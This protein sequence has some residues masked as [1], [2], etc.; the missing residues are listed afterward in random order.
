VFDQFISGILKQNQEMLTEVIDKRL[1]IA[2]YLRALRLYGSCSELYDAL[3][4]LFWGPGFTRGWAARQPLEICEL[5]FERARAGR[6]DIPCE[7]AIK[8]VQEARPVQVGPDLA[9]VAQTV[10]PQGLPLY[11]V[12]TS[13]DPSSESYVAFVR[14]VHLPRD[15]LMLTARQI[16]GVPKITGAIW[17]PD[18]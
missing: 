11:L 15:V 6:T 7:E 1:A 10:L 18:Q 12:T 4:P 9:E 5:A 16:N 2:A 14:F 17:V 8:R 3:A 13:F